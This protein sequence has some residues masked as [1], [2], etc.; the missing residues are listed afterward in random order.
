MPIILGNFDLEN[1]SLCHVCGKT[2]EKLLAIA[3]NSNQEHVAALLMQHA[4]DPAN[5][6]DC[7]VKY[8]EVDLLSTV[9]LEF[10]ILGKP[11][12]VVII[13]C[14][15]AIEAPGTPAIWKPLEPPRYGR[16]LKR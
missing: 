7:V 16:K 9:Y 15:P 10:G 1:G 13:T 11:C 3:S 4:S 6:V 5:V 14:S 12:R 8:N 2:S